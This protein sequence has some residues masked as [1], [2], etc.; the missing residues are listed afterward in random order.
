[1][2]VQHRRRGFHTALLPGRAM[3]SAATNAAAYQ[4]IDHRIHVFLAQGIVERQGE[5]A[6]GDGLGDGERAGE[7]AEHLA[8]VGLR[9]DGGEVRCHS[10]IANP[11]YG[12]HSRRRIRRCP[13]FI[14]SNKARVS[15]GHIGL[16]SSSKAITAPLGI[17]G[18]K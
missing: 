10:K 3:E 15:P 8:D 16:S 5:G 13:I 18:T 7:V 1:M 4:R 11:M 6:G 9:V 17:R 14:L 2:D 12:S